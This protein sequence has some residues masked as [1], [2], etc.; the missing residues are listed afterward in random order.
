MEIEDKFWKKV[1]KRKT[2]GYFL[3]ALIILLTSAAY[4]WTND[5]LKQFNKPFT[6]AYINYSCKTI[7]L[8][9]YYLKEKFNQKFFKKSEFVDEEIMI[10]S[11]HEYNLENIN[12]ETFSETFDKIQFEKK[13]EYQNNLC[14]IILT[15][16]LL[17]FVPTFL[18]VYGMSKTCDCTRFVISNLCTM[19]I[20]VEKLMFLKGKCSVFRLIALI[21]LYIGVFLFRKTNYID[22]PRK[23]DD[24]VSDICILISVFLYSVYL[25]MIKYYSKRFKHYFDFTLILG[26]I[27]LYVLIFIP[28]AIILLV[29]VKVELF[30]LPQADDI[31]LILLTST[32]SSVN[33]ILIYNT[34]ILLSPHLVSA[35]YNL[36]FPIYMTYSLIHGD[37]TFD[38]YY[39][40]GIILLFFS[41]FVFV[42]EHYN[43]VKQQSKQ[44]LLDKRIPKI[45]QT[46]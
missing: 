41:F 7:F 18:F 11:T 43:E 24:V 10:K 25:N 30:E 46:L 44:A 31:K 28:F 32:L 14:K 38:Y 45:N 12:E 27:G 2:I 22:D 26:Y 19:F 21:V 5:L 34:V 4:E 15:L 33:D 6:F 20:L 42:F 1:N 9:I 37:K 3:L 17:Y 29:L 13:I 16:M 40:S 36:Y 8:L 35:G 39:L 23:N